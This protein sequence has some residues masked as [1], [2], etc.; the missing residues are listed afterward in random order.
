MEN[1]SNTS[2]PESKEK[3]DQDEIILHEQEVINA[4]T[5]VKAL[6]DAAG[7]ANNS[8]R[9]YY[10][11]AWLNI[12]EL[13]RVCAKAIDQLEQRFGLVVEVKQERS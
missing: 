2:L 3:M 4:V 9:N 12:K 7:I 5:H 10:G 8:D 11:T 13:E 6:G 1:Y